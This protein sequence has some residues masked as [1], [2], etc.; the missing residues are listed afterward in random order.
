MVQGILFDL[1]GTLLDTLEDLAD[2]CNAALSAR[3][4][5]VHPVDAYRFF[6]GNGI[7]KLIERATPPSLSGEDREAVH[8]LFCEIYGENCL[9][10]TRPYPGIPEALLQLKEKGVKLG[11]VSN[12]DHDFVLDIMERLFPVGLFDRIRG[13][14]PGVPAKP[15][16]DAVL[17]QLEA[18]SLAPGQTLYV[19]DTEV[20]IATARN[21]GLT[22]VAVTWGFRREEELMPY[23]PDRVVRDAAGLVKLL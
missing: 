5:P 7:P 12:K 6:V 17:C 13:R 16:A 11:V 19:G 9:N 4:L 15:A 10:K 22:A 20:D 2:C 21:S 1:D 18:L 8:R 23:R 14:K 3:R